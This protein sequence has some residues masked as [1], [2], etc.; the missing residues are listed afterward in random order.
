MHLRLFF[1]TK[2]CSERNQS[3]ILSPVLYTN[4][5]YLQIN[6][7]TEFPFGFTSFIQPHISF[8]VSVAGGGLVF[9]LW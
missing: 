1:Y 7:N 5:D 4:F 2:A 3:G 8:V 6:N 9:C